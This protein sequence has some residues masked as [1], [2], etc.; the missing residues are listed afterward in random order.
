KFKIGFAIRKPTRRIY[1]DANLYYAVK[2]SEGVKAGM[3]TRAL[4]EKRY[5]NDGGELSESESDEIATLT[6]RLYQCQG[7]LEKVTLN[8]DKAPEEDKNKK[9]EL[10]IEEITK[11]R[12]ELIRFENLRNSFY[13]QTA[14]ARAQRLAS[15]WWV[16]QLSHFRENKDSVYENVFTGD[17]YED[18]LAHFDQMDEGEDEFWNKNTARLAYLISSWNSGQATEQKDFEELDEIFSQ[19]NESENLEEKPKKEEE[20]KEEP[21]EEPREEPEKKPK[22]KKAPTPSEDKPEG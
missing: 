11:I 8:L 13:E 17:T 20:P 22:K 9:T 16:V 4:L 10:I 3:M 12:T 14:E 15:I 18:K 19:L 1:D 7:E 5:E 6:Y 2:I 21:K